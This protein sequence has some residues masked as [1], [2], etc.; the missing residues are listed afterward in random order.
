MREGTKV[1]AWCLGGCGGH[2]F[3]QLTLGHKA[4]WGWGDEELGVVNLFPHPLS[5]YLLREEVV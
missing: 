1:T 2:F 4:L 3:N 5:A